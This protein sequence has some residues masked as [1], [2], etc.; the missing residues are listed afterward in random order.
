MANPASR[1]LAFFT[2]PM[3]GRAAVNL[4]GIVATVD[5]RSVGLQATIDTRSAGLQATIETRNAGIQAT[6]RGC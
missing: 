3:M 2:A 5:A 1:L 4:C 6:V